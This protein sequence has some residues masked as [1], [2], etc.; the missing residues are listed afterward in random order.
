M[1]YFCLEGQRFWMRSQSQYAWTTQSPNSLLSWYGQAVPGH[2]WD[3]CEGHTQEAMSVRGTRTASGYKP[4]ACTLP[5]VDPLM[6]GLSLLWLVHRTHSSEGHSV[7]VRKAHLPPQ[8]HTQM[9]WKGWGKPP[10]LFFLIFIVFFHYHWVTLYPPPPGNHHTV[11][12]VCESFFLFAQFLH[13]LAPPPLAVI[14]SPSMNL[15]VLLVSSVCS[16]DST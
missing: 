16:L 3:K 8:F 12:H 10:S 1:I 7:D 9:S 13:P 11:V 2:S 6:R 5:L 15:S 4:P 14:C